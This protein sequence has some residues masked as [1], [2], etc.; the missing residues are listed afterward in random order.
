[1][2]G[3]A[4]MVNSVDFVSDCILAISH[5]RVTGDS[6]NL[7]ARSIVCANN[8]VGRP[9]A[10]ASDVFSLPLSQRIDIALNDSLEQ[11]R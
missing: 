4:T 1:M 11:A 3:L 5:G 10:G 9:P 8:D 7:K 2:L 6:S